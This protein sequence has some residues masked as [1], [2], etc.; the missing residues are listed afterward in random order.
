MKPRLLNLIS[1][2]CERK[3]SACRGRVFSI[4]QEGLEIAIYSSEGR[5]REKNLSRA[6][7]DH[8]MGLPIIKSL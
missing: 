7:K 4:E 3:I 8:K 1:L 2:L 5:F 6:R